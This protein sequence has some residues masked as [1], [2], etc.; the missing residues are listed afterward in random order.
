MPQE[1]NVTKEVDGEKKSASVQYEFGSNLE[2]AVELFG[3]DVIFNNFRQSAVISLQGILRRHLAN[4]KTQGELQTIADGWKPGVVSRTGKSKVEK[5]RDAF[6]A[7]SPEEKKALLAELR[8]M[9][10]G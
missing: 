7:M 10:R 6:A 4:G 9:A 3:G 5:A 2:E 1:V 8:E